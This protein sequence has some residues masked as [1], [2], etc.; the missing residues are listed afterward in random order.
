MWDNIQ[1]EF[2]REVEGL[3]GSLPER[4]LTRQ[5]R[6][7]ERTHHQEQRELRT[8]ARGDVAVEM[9][10]ARSPDQGNLLGTRNDAPANG[11]DAWLAETV[12]VT[13]EILARS[14]DE[15]LR[16]AAVSVLEAVRGTPLTAT[17]A[18]V[19][20]NSPADLRVRNV[21][22]RRNAGRELWE[23]A[24]RDSRP[25]SQDRWHGARPRTGQAAGFGRGGFMSRSENRLV[26]S[27]NRA[28]NVSDDHGRFLANR[29]E[30][31]ARLEMNREADSYV[32][33]ELRRRYDED[34]AGW[35]Q[36]QDELTRT[37]RQMQQQL[38]ALRLQQQQPQGGQPDL[39][40]NQPAVQPPQP[41]QPPAQPP[42]VQQPP[43]VPIQPPQQA[44]PVQMV[45]N[46]QNPFLLQPPP[47]INVVPPGVQQ[48]GQPLYMGQ[49]VGTPTDWALP[50]P[51]IQ[52]HGRAATPVGARTPAGFTPVHSNLTDDEQAGRQRWNQ[53]QQPRE[54]RVDRRNLKLRTFKGKDIAA[55]KSL[56][57]D[58][59]EQFQWTPQEKKLHL[60][61]NVEDWIRNMFTLMDPETTA[62]EMMTRLVNRFGVNM[63]STEV[64][65]KMLGMERKPGEDLYS[66]ADRVRNLASRANLTVLKRNI[67]MRQTF[68]TALRGNTE[69][70]HFINRYD[71]PDVPDI[72]NTLDIAIE[73]ERRHG[74]TS[75]VEKIR[76]VDA[77]STESTDYSE[78][79]SDEEIGEADVNKISYV[80]VREM[81]TE[82]G[83]RLARQN[84]ELVAV[85]KKQAYA[86]LDEDKRSSSS[87][88]FSSRGRSSGRGRGS[89]PSRSSSSWSKPRR[90]KS[91]DRRAT[92]NREWRTRDK[93]PKS[94]DRQRRRSKDRFKSKRDGKYDKKKREGRV[95]EVRDESPSGS[96]A[97]QASNQSGSET[98]EDQE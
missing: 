20:R 16:G 87:S 7:L 49:R 82:E 97:S 65:N 9:A 85:M 79:K 31:Q 30:R 6:R 24:E 2:D 39:Q 17:D 98:D 19:H 44:Q 90:S 51:M 91:R 69:M 8:L 56:F 5:L 34:R 12:D 77:Y 61:A 1:E 92:S 32:V 35:R 29:L 28:F 43:Q 71:N 66:L 81:T 40:Q 37:V 18:S 26:T 14:R 88:S 13:G 36:Q 55:W 68:F 73:W 64:E 22:D 38:D 45:P 41:P 78:W 15:E 3:L 84:N 27:P 63:T 67:L 25:H 4:R 72:N 52:R 53:E 59:A 62:E 23:A 10:T 42:P 58:F 11:G 47:I 33:R 86:V 48:M 75:K 21:I 93:R 89:Y 96:E 46:Q 76:Q 54:D 80:P 50:P 57:E 83:R 95:E 74:T 60:K 70:Q 94:G